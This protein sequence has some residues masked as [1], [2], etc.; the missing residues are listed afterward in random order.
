VYIHV[1]NRVQLIWVPGHEGIIGNET[2]D[3]LART[4]S[5]YP[6]REPEP[7]AASRRV[8]RKAIRD[9]TETIK[10]TGNP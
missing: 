3:Q 2:A 4:G 9:W 1:F 10:N 5:E 6:F 7:L 8:A